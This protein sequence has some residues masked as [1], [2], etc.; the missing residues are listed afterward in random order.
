MNFMLLTKRP[1]RIAEC[2]P[3]DWRDGGTYPNAW[4][5]VTCGVRSAYKRAEILRSIPCA[6]RFLSIEPLMESVADIDLNGIGWVAVGGMSGP[7][8]KKH[9]MDLA[10]AAEVHDLCRE[11]GI[12]FLYKQSSNFHSERGINGLS[13]CLAKRAGQDADPVTVPLLRFYPKTDLPLLPFAEHGKRFTMSDYIL[14]QKRRYWLST[15]SRSLN[16]V[17]CRVCGT[18]RW[19][20]QLLIV[21]KISQPMTI[22]ILPISLQLMRMAFPATT[23]FSMGISGQ[24]S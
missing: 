14:Y 7:L 10:W 17:V 15:R 18:W 13:L 12:P 23:D 5:G 19:S 2:L 16:M 4:L 24:P 21:H 9:R 6:L 20:S 1:E 22:P 3:D 8:H 11:K